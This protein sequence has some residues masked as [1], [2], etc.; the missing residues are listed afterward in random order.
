MTS[1]SMTARNKVVDSIGVNG[2]AD[3]YSL[4]TDDPGTTGINELAGCPRKTT[5]YPVSTAGEATN[6]GTLFDVPAG[7]T[8]RFFGRW[9]TSTAPTGEYSCSVTR[10]WA[11]WSA[12]LTAVSARWLRLASAS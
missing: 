9:S 5:T 8:I 12:A 4:H 11:T 10:R 7:S 2:G 3:W 1:Y 6:G